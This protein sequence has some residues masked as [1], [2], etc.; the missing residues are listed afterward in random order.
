MLHTDLE[1]MADEDDIFLSI[2]TFSGIKSLLTGAYMD[3]P[4]TWEALGYRPY[5]NWP[6]PAAGEGNG[7][8]HRARTDASAIPASAC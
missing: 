1:A 4:A 8:P 2:V 5:P 6:P 7:T 3:L